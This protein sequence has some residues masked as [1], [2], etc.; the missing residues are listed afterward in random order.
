MEVT[1]VRVTPQNGYTI[2]AFRE[3]EGLKVSDLASAVGVSEP[4]MRN[5]ET[6]NRP[7]S[8]EHLG[9]I[10]DALN[11]PVAALVRVP[12]SEYSDNRKKTRHAV[13]AKVAEEAA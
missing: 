10:S 4:H 13:L 2:R 8:P 5:I 1:P 9:R 12:A 3:R 6:E 7:A 11:V